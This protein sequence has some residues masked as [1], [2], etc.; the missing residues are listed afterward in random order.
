MTIVPTLDR[1]AVAAVICHV[2]PN[3]DD[4]PVDLEE[5]CVVE[6]IAVGGA[7]GV[8]AIGVEVMTLRVAKVLRSLAFP[9]TAV[10]DELLKMRAAYAVLNYEHQTLRAAAQ[11]VM[12]EMPIGP[13]ASPAMIALGGNAYRPTAT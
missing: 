12:S 4:A 2:F 11:R 3:Q 5:F 9:D 7:A 13:G 1:L 10:A 6:G 8:A